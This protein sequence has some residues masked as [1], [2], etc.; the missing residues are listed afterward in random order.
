[1]LPSALPMTSLASFS[2]LEAADQPPD[3]A[4]ERSLA[5]L[6]EAAERV[7]ALRARF[8][9]SGRCRAFQRRFDRHAAPVQDRSGGQEP[10]A[11]HPVRLERRHLSSTRPPGLARDGADSGWSDLSAAGSLSACAAD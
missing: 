1:M 2:D 10:P 4:Q 3:A 7:Q 9:R 8:A 6:Q 11:G 5:T